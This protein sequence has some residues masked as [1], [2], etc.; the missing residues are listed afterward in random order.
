MSFPAHLLLPLASSVGY[1]V[2]VLLVK[3]SAFFGVGLWRTTFVA[4]VATGLCF[5]PL[6]LLGGPGQP[7]T[8]LWQPAVVGALFFAGQ[9]CTF[10]AING[11]VSLATPVLGLKILMV[12]LLSSV[13]LADPVPLKW[14]VAAA[15]STGAIALLNGGGQSGRRKVGTTVMAAS[16]AAASFALSDVLIQKWAP[17]WG[18]GRFLPLLFWALALFS[19]GLIPFF[20]APLREISRP[21]WNWLLPGALVLALQAASMTYAV[22]VFGEATAMNVVYSSRGLWSVVAVWLIGHWFRNEE[23]HLGAVVLRRR[24]GG[25]LLMLAAIGLVMV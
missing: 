14:W 19:L 25:A 23:Q 5:A 2:A 18:A 8:M 17:A 9:V 11:D 21:A 22:A 15:L 24:L 7:A 6:W 16:L 20:R 3:R 12:A 1:V 10:W 13:L 4:N